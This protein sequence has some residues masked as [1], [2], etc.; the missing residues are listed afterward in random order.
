MFATSHHLA[1]L[2]PAQLGNLDQSDEY[3]HLIAGF[4]PGSTVRMT[5]MMPRDMILVTDMYQTTL[6]PLDGGLALYGLQRDGSDMVVTAICRSAEHDSDFDD[7]SVVLLRTALP[8]LVAV[9]AIAGRMERDRHNR[10][11][12][13][14][15]LDIV[16][17]GVIVLDVAGHVIQAN[18]AAEALL[19]RGDRV[20]RVRTGIVA[21]E[22]ADDRRL[23]RAIETARMFGHG[24]DEHEKA[25]AAARPFQVV[26][27][28]CR[29]GWPLI[30][31]V[32]P[33][34]RASGR[35]RNGDV[36]VHLRDPGKASCLSIAA[37]RAELGLTLREATLVS[38][39]AAGAT[40]VQAASHM[41]ISPG[42]ARQYLKTIFLKAGVGGQT[43]LLRLVS[44]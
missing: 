36:V 19:V 15:A 37:L 12:A 20:R 16:A 28:R 8:H 29:P 22:R 5:D 7:A 31:T 14:D 42:T 40:L 33:A 3:R 17:D 26:I 13:R 41:E 2:S 38:E 11:C 1:K 18:A 6:R 35:L 44:R 34:D 43:D 4:S 27:G 9:T 24:F 39:L 30:A 32:T 21:T 23:Q 10:E 25:A